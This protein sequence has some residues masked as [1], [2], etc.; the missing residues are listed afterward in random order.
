MILSNRKEC[1]HLFQ[2][3]FSL[4]ESLKTHLVVNFV[5]VDSD[6]LKFLDELS[7]YFEQYGEIEDL[8]LTFKRE[9][10]GKG[11]GFLLFKDHQSMENVLDDYTK[12][13][14]NGV[15]FECQIAKPKFSENCD[16]GVLQEESEDVNTN[17]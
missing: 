14:I 4:E 8:N 5:E 6:S 13:E 10:K 11:F 17:T 16:C 2:E 15:W 1:L 3:K 9:N 7:S 12:H